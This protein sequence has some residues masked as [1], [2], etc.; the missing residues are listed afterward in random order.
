MINSFFQGLFSL[1][2][3]MASVYTTP[4]NAVLSNAFP[5]LN[6]MLG[7]ITNIL[8]MISSII[9][10][11]VNLIPTNCRNLIIF[12]F[13]FW[14]SI[15]PLRVVLWNVTFGLDFI[16]RINLFSSR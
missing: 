5:D 6:N 8:S 13:T 15:W 9:G 1:L 11:F 16:K 7:V 3:N 2:T 12:I 14:L 10:W 4:V